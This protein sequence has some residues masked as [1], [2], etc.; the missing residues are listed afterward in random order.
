MVAELVAW[1]K[2]FCAKNPSLCQV[3]LPGET[4]ELKFLSG[5]ALKFACNRRALQDQVQP[6]LFLSPGLRNSSVVFPFVSFPPLLMT[7]GGAKI[8]HSLVTSTE[9]R[10]AL[11]L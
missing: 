3:C 5:F 4:W 6:W 8:G 1:Q 11:P 9:M 7:E 2:G 10:M